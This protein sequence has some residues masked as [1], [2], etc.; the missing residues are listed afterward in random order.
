MFPNYFFLFIFFEIPF[1][2]FLQLVFGFLISVLKN[3]VVLKI[4]FCRLAATP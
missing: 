4:I 1:L 2:N 3:H